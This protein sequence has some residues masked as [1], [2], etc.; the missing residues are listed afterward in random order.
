MNLNTLL[1]TTLRMA[2]KL[3][4]IPVVSFF[5]P[6]SPLDSIFLHWL[7]ISLVPS[8]KTQACS[9]HFYMGVRFQPPK[10]ALHLSWQPWH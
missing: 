1:L 6:P 8:F 3:L 4:E 10:W 2:L 7:S 5:A 9:Q